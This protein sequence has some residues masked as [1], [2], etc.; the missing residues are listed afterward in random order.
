MKKIIPVWLCIS[1][2]IGA[3]GILKTYDFIDPDTEFPLFVDFIVILFWVP[4]FS[5]VLSTLL[6][7]F[8]FI[9]KSKLAFTTVA[10]I[11][12]ITAILC[13]FSIF[14]GVYGNLGLFIIN[15]EFLLLTVIHF[16]LTAVSNFFIT[17]KFRFH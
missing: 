7:I 10:I 1:L 8:F 13:S 2:I 4:S 5:L 3:F 14:E 16:Y 11:S 15:F 17:K 6:L 9:V 12:I